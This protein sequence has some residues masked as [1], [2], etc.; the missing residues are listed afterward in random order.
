ME[1]VLQNRPSCGVSVCKRVCTS[2]ASH[3]PAITHHTLFALVPVKSTPPAMATPHTDVLPTSVYMAVEEL[4]S[5]VADN[6]VYTASVARDVMSGQAHLAQQRK[7]K[8]DALERYCKDADKLKMLHD[9]HRST[10]VRT[11]ALAKHVHTAS[12]LCVRTT[13]WCRMG[14]GRGEAR[15]ENACFA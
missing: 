1:F 4:E 6:A 7:R 12:K 9:V 5:I 14:G 2:P 8:Q 15:T 10:I 11:C 3:L 13:G